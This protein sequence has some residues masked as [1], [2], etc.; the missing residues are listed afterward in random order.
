VEDVRNSI[1]GWNAGRAIP[2]PLKNMKSFLHKYLRKWTPPAAINRQ[3]AMPHIKV[4]T[5]QF[6]F[7]QK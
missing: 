1:E 4:I 6:T 7:I 2:C 3:N 5:I